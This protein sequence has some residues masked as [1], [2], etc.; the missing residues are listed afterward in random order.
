MK[1]PSLYNTLHPYTYLYSNNF[2]ESVRTAL[3]PF[4]AGC[5]PV[6]QA[7][8]KGMGRRGVRGK[9]IGKEGRRGSGV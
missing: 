3:P 1:S 9:E 5:P 8:E 2:Q 4:H 7:R 6:V